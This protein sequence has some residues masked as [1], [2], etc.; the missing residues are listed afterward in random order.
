[1]PIHRTLRCCPVLGLALFA[2]ANAGAQTKD[3]F[4]TAVAPVLAKHCSQCHGGAVQTSGIDFTALGDG[5]AASAKPELWRK[6]R[7]K[8]QARLMPPPPLPS[9]SA[10]DA[11]SVTQWIDSLT[12]RP[13]ETASSSG[14][15]RVTARR[16]NR[17]E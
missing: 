2:W 13:A 16:L 15:G 11:A 4:Q 14:P 10:S 1:M 6:V 3:T 9:L 5:R 12:G 8:V 17:A 7:E